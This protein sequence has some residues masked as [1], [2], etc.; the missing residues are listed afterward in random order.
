MGT[1]Q[2]KEAR[3]HQDNTSKVSKTAPVQHKMYIF[4]KLN[5]SKGSEKGVND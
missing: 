4:I 2:V 3:L 5:A 1:T